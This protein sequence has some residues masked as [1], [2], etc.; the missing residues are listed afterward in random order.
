MTAAVAGAVRGRPS[1]TSLAESLELSRRINANLRDE[2]R[3]ERREGRVFAEE[4]RALAS[5]IDLAVRADRLDLAQHIG[6]A[7]AVTADRRIRQ[8]GSVVL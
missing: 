8:I 4:V 6:G 1:A 7:L 2:L 5:R 3:A